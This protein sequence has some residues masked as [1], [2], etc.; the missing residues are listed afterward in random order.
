[1]DN[2]NLQNSIFAKAHSPYLQATIV[3]G[4]GLSF[5]LLGAFFTW[6][7]MMDMGEKFP[8]TT[9]GSFILF[10][11]IFNSVFGLSSKDINQYMKQSILAYIAMVSALVLFAFLFS[12]KWINDVGSFRWIFF[13]LTFGYLMFISIIGMMKM[14]YEFFMK[15][16]ERKEK[17]EQNN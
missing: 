9:A 8:W 2:N 15:N 1:M 16:D 3:F 5:M 12:G 7:G 4:L 6:T 10:Y 14:V 17:L 11:A 13:V